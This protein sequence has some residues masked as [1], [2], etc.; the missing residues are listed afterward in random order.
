MQKQESRP[1]KP[2]SAFEKFVRA[3]AGV[4]KEELQ[5]VEEAERQEKA[6]KR[7]TA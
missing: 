1:P 4:P 5:R 6:R 3:I 2:L 7:K